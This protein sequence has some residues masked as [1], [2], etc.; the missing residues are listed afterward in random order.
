MGNNIQPKTWVA[1]IK[2]NQ[3]RYPVEITVQ[4]RTMQDAMELIKGQYGANVQIFQGPS[5]K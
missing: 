2:N 4:A 1:S 3:M 5:P